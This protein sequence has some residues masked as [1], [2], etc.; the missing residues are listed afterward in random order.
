MLISGRPS[1][2]PP[3][4]SLEMQPPGAHFFGRLRA[5]EVGSFLSA[6]ASGQSCEPGK[7]CNSRGRKL[8]IFPPVVLALWLDG[9][10]C[11]RLGGAENEEEK[12]AKRTE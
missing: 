12:D 10:A 2:R 9:G 6:R 3:A 11:G 4:R 1:V 7:K 8:M 5:P